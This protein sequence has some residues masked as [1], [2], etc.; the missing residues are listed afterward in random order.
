[1]LGFT[2]VSFFNND[3]ERSAFNLSPFFVALFAFCFALAAGTVWEIY[4]YLADGLF[5]INMQVYVLEDGIQL[6]GHMALADTMKDLIVHALS[7]WIISTIGYYSIK[8]KQK[9][10]IEV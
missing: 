1:A 10:R 5:N 9:A 7:A 4:E 3:T 8:R 6:A 2:L